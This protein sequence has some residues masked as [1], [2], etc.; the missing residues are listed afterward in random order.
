MWLYT[1]SQW[2]TFIYRSNHFS[3]QIAFWSVLMACGS[4]TVDKTPCSPCVKSGKGSCWGRRLG[5]GST[6][7]LLE[8][9]RGL[10]SECKPSPWIQSVLSGLDVGN[11]MSHSFWLCLSWHSAFR[12][13]NSEGPL[14][15]KAA[16]S[17][18]IQAY[19]RQEPGLHLSLL[20]F[21]FSPLLQTLLSVLE[22]SRLHMQ[23]ERLPGRHRAHQVG[24]GLYLSSD[25][26]PAM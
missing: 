26:S 3:R 13:I 24:L 20:F 19:L 15:R 8:A 7:F 21:F 18:V 12:R 11:L 22:G 16:H 10:D 5:H 9:G 14:K 4:S 23:I 25:S 1:N 6:P 17:M 2:V